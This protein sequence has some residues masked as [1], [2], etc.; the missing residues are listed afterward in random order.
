LV[1]KWEFPTSADR[2]SLFFFRNGLW[3]N[4]DIAHT[5]FCLPWSSNESAGNIHNISIRE[6]WIIH[7]K[8][9]PNPHTPSD[10]RYVVGKFNAKK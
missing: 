5:R 9:Q 3:P 6:R 7:T 8:N 10:V 1:E 4:R 2:A